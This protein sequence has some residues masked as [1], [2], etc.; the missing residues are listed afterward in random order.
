MAIFS[1]GKYIL[2][3]YA[4]FVFKIIDYYTQLNI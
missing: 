3:N 1:F 4:W 2:T